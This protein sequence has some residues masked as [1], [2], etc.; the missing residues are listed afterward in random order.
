M[1]QI[2][3]GHDPGTC[4]LC[5]FAGHPSTVPENQEERGSLDYWRAACSTR[6]VPCF[7]ELATLSEIARNP[8]VKEVIY[9]P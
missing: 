5:L 7:Q 6:P 1:T 2:E 3:P 9:A 8:T 4:P